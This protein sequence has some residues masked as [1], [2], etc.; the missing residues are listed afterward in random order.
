MLTQKQKHELEQ[1]SLEASEEK[2]KKAKKSGKQLPLVL[3]DSKELPQPVHS[4]SQ[5]GSAGP[6]DMH[7]YHVD[8]A[9]S[10]MDWRLAHPLRGNFSV[11][12]YGRPSSMPSVPPPLAEQMEA[13][14]EID[15]SSSGARGSKRDFCTDSYSTDIHIHKSPK[16]C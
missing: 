10:F 12:W 14:D 5:S 13:G 9:E 11:R 7:E 8:A 16:V 6:P 3:T 4:W 1:A 2:F 15:L